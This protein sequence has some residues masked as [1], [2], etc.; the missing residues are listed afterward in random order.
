MKILGRNPNGLGRWVQSIHP[1]DNTNNN[2]YIGH[3]S[4][5]IDLIPGVQDD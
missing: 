3:L 2:N 4:P 5:E 1:C